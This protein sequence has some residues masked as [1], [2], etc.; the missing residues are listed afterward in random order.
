VAAGRQ[1]PVESSPQQVDVAPL[2]DLGDQAA[3]HLGGSGG[4][5][6][7]RALPG[8]GSQGRFEQVGQ[9]S[10]ALDGGALRLTQTLADAPSS[11][12]SVSP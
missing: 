6:E 9:T 7:D 8:L 10:I 5:A 11:S 4:R 12:K 2:I 3:G 1:D